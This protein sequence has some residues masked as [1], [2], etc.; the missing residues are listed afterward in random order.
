M[1]EDVSSSEHWSASLPRFL[2]VSWF[3]L[4]L[5]PP[6]LSIAFLGY[7]RLDPNGRGPLYEPACALF[8]GDLFL[9]YCLAPM[10]LLLF[11]LLIANR[12]GNVGWRLCLQAVFMLAAEVLLC[13]KIFSHFDL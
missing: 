13:S 4:V 10:W 9:S 12:R 3:A 7:L 6:L 8:F 11:V 5:G 2:R 1:T